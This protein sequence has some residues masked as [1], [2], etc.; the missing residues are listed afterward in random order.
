MLSLNRH[1]TKIN[2]SGNYEFILIDMIMIIIGNKFNE[3]D[4]LQLVEAFEVNKT[5][6]YSFNMNY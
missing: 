3:L 6:V 2:L 4:V 1:L 5:I